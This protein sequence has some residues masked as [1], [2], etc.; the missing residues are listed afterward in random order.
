MLTLQRARPVI[1]LAFRDRQIAAKGAVEPRIQRQPMTERNH[2]LQARIHDLEAA[3]TAEQAKTVRLEAALR[4]R[5]LQLEKLDG[6]EGFGTPQARAVPVPFARTDKVMKP[7]ETIAQLRPYLDTAYYLQENPDVAAAGMEPVRHY[8]LH[9]EGE[10]RRPRA[11]FDPVRY[12][13]MHPALAQFDGNLF[14]HF[15][16]QEQA[17]LQDPKRKA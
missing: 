12:R 7:K 15:L 8:V 9:G 2:V 4:Q 6:G 11:D 1:A 17:A 10:G 13:V 14:W 16:T 3:L 5:S